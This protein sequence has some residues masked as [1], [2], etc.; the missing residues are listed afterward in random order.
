MLAAFVDGAVPTPQTYIED[1][2]KV[3][4]FVKHNPGYA[5]KYVEEYCGVVK[6]KAEKALNRLLSRGD[7]EMRQDPK[8]PTAYK[9]WPVE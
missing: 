4:Q 6:S 9:V 8:D 7:I 2:A 3:L 1:Q 5:T